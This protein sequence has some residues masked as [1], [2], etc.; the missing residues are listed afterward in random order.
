[1][2]E[3]LLKQLK[4]RYP[5]EASRYTDE[6]LLAS[7]TA[8]AAIAESVGIDDDTDRLRLMSLA[9]LLSPEQR[10]S[11]LCNGVLRRILNNDDWTMPQRLDFLYEHLV[12]RP[13]S[14][15][16]EDFGPRFVPF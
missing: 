8:W 1:M 7:L 2:H 14:D 3:T 13:V 6:F 9:V 12:G 10:R 5:R 11:K 16:E 15:P 4:W